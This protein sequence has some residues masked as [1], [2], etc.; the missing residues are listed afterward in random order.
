MDM[1]PAPRFIRYK[2]EETGGGLRVLQST[3][4]CK[5]L[6]NREFPFFIKLWL[7]QHII[8]S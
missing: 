2:C 4:F 5:W 6:E 8:Y 3:E 1:G 7:T